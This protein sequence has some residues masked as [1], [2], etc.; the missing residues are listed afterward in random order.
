MIL[1]P[2]IKAIKVAVLIA[3]ATLLIALGAYVAHT[4]Q[5]AKVAKLEGSVSSLE[6]RIRTAQDAL[7]RDEAVRTRL[8]AK[9]AAA[10]RETALL[11]Q[12]LSAALA[13]HP[14]WSQQPVPPEVQDALR[15]P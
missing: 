9:N 5:S 15:Q 11:R 10:A 8:R 14:Q 2:Y 4:R 6:Q 1:T 7:K 3:S 13:A 12:R